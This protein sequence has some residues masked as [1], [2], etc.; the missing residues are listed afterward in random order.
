MKFSIIT[1][2]YN[3]K[4]HIE[5][6][7]K[8]VISQD[9]ENIE[10]I[11]IDG[12]SDDG[13]AE[14]IYNAKCRIENEMVEFKFISEKDNGIYEALNKGLRMT[15]GDVVGFLHSDDIFNN[16]NVISKIAK[17][18]EDKNTD[19]V[20]SDLVYV[21]KNDT[22]SVLRYWKAGEFNYSFLKK[23]WMPP[24]PAFF[25]KKNIY[26][27]YGGFDTSFKIASDY[28][29]VLRF[30][31]KH[32]ISSA[33]L[34]EVTINMRTGGASNK[35]IASVIQKS[36]ED[37]SALKINAIPFPLM[38]LVFKNTRKIKQ[39]VLRNWN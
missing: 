36:R 4:T 8:S 11:I 20:Y 15:T 37:Y 18:F 22:S 16:E 31:A 30:L 32:K 6:C 10:Y 9:Y 5:D 35:N 2:V 17:V 1:A 33:Y 34:P 14:K 27:K 29:I 38:A 28:E 24:H 3:N 23:G 21:Y 25:V 19:S 7:I 13:T 39:F 12:G 26:D